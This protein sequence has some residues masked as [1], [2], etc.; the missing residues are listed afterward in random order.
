MTC[1]SGNR[2]FS[3]KPIF[4]RSVMT[5]ST[6]SCEWLKSISL[7]FQY[8]LYGMLFY[9]KFHRNATYHFKKKGCKGFI[10]VPTPGPIKWSKSTG[11]IELNTCF[12]YTKISINS[13]S[14]EQFSSLIRGIVFLSQRRFYF[15]PAFSCCVWLTLI[16]CSFDSFKKVSRWVW[17]S[18]YFN[19]PPQKGGVIGSS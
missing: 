2:Y 6:L 16:T 10:F 17:L 14:K 18:K 19:E 1:F 5:S 8:F 7:H 4:S 13:F 3:G 9:V 11:K 15:F 12:T